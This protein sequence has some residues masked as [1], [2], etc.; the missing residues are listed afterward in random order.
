M[1]RAVSDTGYRLARPQHAVYQARQRYQSNWLEKEHVGFAT[2]TFGTLRGGVK[3]KAKSVKLAVNYIDVHIQEFPELAKILDAKRASLADGNE[4]KVPAVAAVAPEAAAPAAA[5]E[6]VESEA[7]AQAA[8]AQAGAQSD[9]EAKQ[10]E[11]EVEAELA[12]ATESEE[13]ST[14]E[15]EEANEDAAHPTTPDAKEDEPVQPLISYE[16]G[17]PWLQLMVPNKEKRK[18]AEDD[19]PLYV[20]TVDGKSSSQLTPVFDC[21]LNLELADMGNSSLEV[22]SRTV[23][24]IAVK[25]TA[26]KRG[27]QEVVREFLAG[28][29]QRTIF[30][31]RTATGIEESMVLFIIESTIFNTTSGEDG[32]AVEIEGP[33]MFFTVVSVAEHNLNA[34]ALALKGKELRAVITI[35]H[36]TQYDENVAFAVK[37]LNSLTKTGEKTGSMKQPR[38]RLAKLKEHVMEQLFMGEAPSTTRTRKAPEIYEPFESS[39]VQPPKRKATPKPT[40]ATGGRSTKSRAANKRDSSSHAPEGGSAESSLSGCSGHG[41]GSGSFGQEGMPSHKRKRGE[42]QPILSG[43]RP[44]DI[45]Q[46]NA[47]TAMAHFQARTL[48]RSTTSPPNTNNTCYVY[49]PTLQMEISSQRLS[50]AQL[51]GDALGAS[52]AALAISTAGALGAHAIV[53]AGG[54]AADG[55]ADFIQARVGHQQQQQLRFVQQQPQFVQ[56]QQPQ[57]VQQQPQFVQ[58]QQPQLVQQQQRQW[59]LVQRPPP[60]FV[61]QQQQQQ[62]PQFV[63]QQQPQFVQQQQPQFV[64]QQQPQFVQQQQQPQ[65]VQQQQEPQFVQQ[66]QPQFVLQ[67]PQFVQQQ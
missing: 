62:Q 10:G 43:P 58:Q 57:F 5:P 13:E 67:Q 44:Y 20:G 30:T 1:L 15:E 29:S 19:G 59:Q 28:R 53:C 4:W 50:T 8:A 33:S 35:E 60:Q 31:M 54:G 16:D 47:L 11:G 24:A 34:A 56:H 26:K 25:G 36:I 2:K 65:F 32:V 6:A 12:G 38:N 63:Q 46:V 22:R 23:Y 18:A 48:S 61:Q 39:T 37:E 41:N 14:Q 40:T 66:Q 9:E 55:V 7:V 49:V 52:A 45:G 42:P 64:Q 3:N 27:S 51:R 17:S 21:V